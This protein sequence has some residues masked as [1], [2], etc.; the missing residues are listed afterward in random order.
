L[1]ARLDERLVAVRE[2]LAAIETRLDQARDSR[3]SMIVLGVGAIMTS[4]G[5]LAVA[6]LT[7]L[8]LK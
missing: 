8:L 5:A 4:C 7:H 2:R 1:V 6:L 3:R